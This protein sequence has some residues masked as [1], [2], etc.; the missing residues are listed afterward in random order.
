M[1]YAFKN[2]VSLWLLKADAQLYSLLS[3]FVLKEEKPNLSTETHKVNMAR[4]E[5]LAL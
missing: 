3:Y 5:Q 1:A 2:C 4:S